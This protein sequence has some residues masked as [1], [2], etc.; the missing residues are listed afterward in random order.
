MFGRDSFASGLSDS[1][2]S[3][4]ENQ[5]KGKRKKGKGKGKINKIMVDYANDVVNSAGQV[6]QAF[7]YKC[8]YVFWTTVQ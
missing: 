3:E 8:I 4:G 5:F 1:R 7:G 2:S 6:Q